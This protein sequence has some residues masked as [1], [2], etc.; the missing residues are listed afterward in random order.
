VASPWK[1]V[2]RTQRLAGLRSLTWVKHINGNAG[3][4]SG[5]SVI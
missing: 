3:V 5:A 4:P 1:E 2:L